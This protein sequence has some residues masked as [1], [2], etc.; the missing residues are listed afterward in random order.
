MESGSAADCDGRQMF[1][2]SF[3]LQGQVNVSSSETW[4]C[5]VRLP[6]RGPS[7]TTEIVFFLLLLFSR[8][9]IFKKFWSFGIFWTFSNQF[10]RPPLICV[11]FVP[12]RAWISYPQ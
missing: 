10:V 11:A 1:G 8:F 4:S 6:H 12:S 2:R 7:G 3:F 5:R 9:W